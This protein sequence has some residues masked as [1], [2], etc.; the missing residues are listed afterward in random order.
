MA[1]DKNF[2][3]YVIDQID[4]V[5][6][7]KFKKMFGE[8]AVYCDEKI[9]LLICD[10]KVFVKPTQ[11]GKYF[12]DELVEV[13]PYPGAK[14]YFFVG[15]TFENRDWFSQLVELTAKELSASPKKC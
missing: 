15:D 8:Y 9:V 13:S 3:E 12:I 4:S 14:P 5:R 1:S 10:N 2:V 7:I 6:V 11:N